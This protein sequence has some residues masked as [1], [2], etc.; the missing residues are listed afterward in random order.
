M[1][2]YQQYLEEIEHALQMIIPEDKEGLVHEKIPLK[3]AKSMNY[4]LLAGGKRLRPVMLVSAYAMKDRH[5]KQA[6]PFALALEM[7]HT[8]SLI[9]DDLPSID[10]DAYRRGKLTNHKVF[11][12]ANAVLAGDALLNLAYETVFQHME[13]F[14]AKGIQAAKQIAFRA[15][16]CG[17]IAGQS[18]DIAQE[19]EGGDEQTLVYIQTHKTAALFMAAMEA[20][21]ILGGGTQQEIAF[22]REYGHCFG[23]AFQMI[24]DLLDIQGDPALLGKTVGKDAIQQKLTWPSLLGVEQTRERAEGYIQKATKAMSIFGE[25]G[26]FLIYL[27]QN[28][29]QRVQ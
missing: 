8:Y 21:V 24:D 11:G 17:M 22:A 16:S 5:W 12:E 23:L 2:E 6:L 15:G 28:T 26:K 29:L 25:E 1:R 14:G 13:P 4:S 20:G 10:N 18:I 19:G 27:A 3:L 7:I 9:H